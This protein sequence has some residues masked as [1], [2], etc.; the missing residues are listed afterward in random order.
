[1]PDE[2]DFKNYKTFDEFG[3]TLEGNKYIHGLYLKAVN[4]P[5]RREILKIINKKHKISESE[6]FEILK[7]NKVL[8]NKEIFDYNIDYLLKAFCIQRSKENPENTKNVYEITQNGKVI[9]YL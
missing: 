7:K 9:E 5:V 1:M 4:H 6:L 8:K 2:F 3:K